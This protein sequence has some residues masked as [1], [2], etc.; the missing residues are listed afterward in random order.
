M[1]GPLCCHRQ[2]DSDLV[3]RPTELRTPLTL[4]QAPL[5][6]MQDARKLPPSE[7][8]KVE[9]AMRNVKRLRKLVDVSSSLFSTQITGADCRSVRLGYE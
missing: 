2:L 6:Q 8:A 1:V 4:I 7:L 5:E 9:M 3:L